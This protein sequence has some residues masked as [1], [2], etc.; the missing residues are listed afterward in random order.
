M[1]ER[2]ENRKGLETQKMKQTSKSVHGNR[3]RTKTSTGGREESGRRRAIGPVKGGRAGDGGSI[4]TAGK[5]IMGRA[6]LAKKRL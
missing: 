2:K 1:G 5:F 4:R 3:G 6:N